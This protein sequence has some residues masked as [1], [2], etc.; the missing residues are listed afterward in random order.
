[1]E[2]GANAAALSPP[3]SR[4]SLPPACP[5]SLPSYRPL[6]P[7]PRR[8]AVV[9]EHCMQWG[10]E[11]RLRIKVTLDTAGARRRLLSLVM[12]PARAEHTLCIRPPSFA[13]LEGTVELSWC[14]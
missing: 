8:T 2:A 13:A 14:R 1:M 3:G 5:P 4:R 9:I 11:Q 10:G 12:L 6:A 7:A